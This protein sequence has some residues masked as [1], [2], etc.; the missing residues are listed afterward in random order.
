M[1]KIIWQNKDFMVYR[2]KLHGN[3]CYRLTL[4]LKINGKDIHSFVGV[5]Y[6]EI[7]FALQDLIKMSHTVSIPCQEKKNDMNDLMWY[8]RSFRQDYK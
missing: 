4:S 8:I 5:L 7:K 2:S 6:T 3:G 1:K